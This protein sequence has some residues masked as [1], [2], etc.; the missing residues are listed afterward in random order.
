MSLG[1]LVVNYYRAL[2]KNLYLGF[3]N[4]KGFDT[5]EIQKD[6]IKEIIGDQDP[7]HY[8]NTVIETLFRGKFSITPPNYK[9]VLDEY[10]PNLIIKETQETIDPSNLSSGEKIIFWLAIQTFL[11]KYS[12][13]NISI[14]DKT[15]VL[16]DEPDSHLHP[17][18]VV[19]FYDCLKI[20]NT[21]LNT[22]FIMNTH[23]PTTVALCPNQN[24]F[25]LE[26]IIEKDRFEITKITKDGAIS[27]LLEGVS[28]ISLNPEN[29]RQVYVENSND[30]YVYE[31]IYTAIKNKSLIID[32]N[33]NLSFISSGPK[34]ADSELF[35]H[36]HSFY[37]ESP[38]ATKL[39][40]KI[41]GDGNCQQVIGIV[42]YLTS[43][44]SRTVR[45][46][47][48]W[49][50]VNRNHKEEVVVFAKEYAYSIENVIYDPISI[51]AYLTSNGMLKPSN[52]FE[53]NEDYY[54]RECLENEEILQIIVDKVTT[55]ILGRNNQK[56]HAINYV[57]GITLRGDR[58]YYIPADNKN[59]HHFE[60]IL[61]KTYGDIHKIRLNKSG[62]PMIY[63][64]VT[65]AT[66]GCLGAGF[67][68]KK[69]EEAFS[70]LQK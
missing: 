9:T 41:N 15:I 18:M 27:Q 28:Q 12:A 14:S 10:H 40:E 38:A 17:Q 24:I 4:Y 59:G 20:L 35:K 64:F 63:Y 31:N 19:D 65:I 39:V 66:L 45:G 5:K 55:E 43:S 53:C 2:D 68:N 30:S 1:H 58:E 7:H 21:S 51:Y 52:F 13:K 57:N 56:N 16:L 3:L 23:S 25:N 26:H 48:D 6:K 61:L 29:N 49:D 67:V 62:R 69:F 32:P 46:L 33:I 42:N 22:L 36:I 44:G 60:R 47:I 70:S 50:K 8:L 11:T 54:W 34:I 37:G